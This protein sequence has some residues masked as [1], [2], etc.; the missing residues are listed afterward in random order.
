MRNIYK[1]KSL[2]LNIIPRTVLDGFFLGIGAKVIYISGS[3]YMVS[4]WYKENE[5]SVRLPHNLTFSSSWV[6]LI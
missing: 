6:L 3:R 5:K 4:W 2:F 1:F